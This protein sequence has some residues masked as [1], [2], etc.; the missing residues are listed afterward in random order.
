M[1][2]FDRQEPSGPAQPIVA[3]GLVSTLINRVERASRSRFAA[4]AA[5]GPT[6]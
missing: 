1:E 4:G 3:K 6:A 2:Q 5:G